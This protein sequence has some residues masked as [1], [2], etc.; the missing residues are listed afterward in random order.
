MVIDLIILY[1]YHIV[2]TDIYIYIYIFMLSLICIL[3]ITKLFTNVI[4]HCLCTSAHLEN[5]PTPLKIRSRNLTL[6]NPTLHQETS[7]R[8]LI[9]YDLV[10]I[11]RQ[12]YSFRHNMNNSIKYFWSNIQDLCSPS[13]YRTYAVLYIDNLNKCFVLS[14]FSFYI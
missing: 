10:F 12:I 11:N 3:W 6:H 13:T 7:G 14:I 2:T 1:S 9:V 5:S 4:L 8:W